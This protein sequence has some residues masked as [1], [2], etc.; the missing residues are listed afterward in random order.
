MDPGLVKSLEEKD[1]ELTALLQKML[2]EEKMPVW[3]TGEQYRCFLQWTKDNPDLE[4]Q[5]LGLQPRIGLLRTDICEKFLKFQVGTP[6]PEY[7][8]KLNDMG[9]WETIPTFVEDYKRNPELCT[10][11]MK[12][13]EI[14]RTQGFMV[15]AMEA[16]P[17]PGIHSITKVE[18]IS[19]LAKYILPFFLH[20]KVHIGVQDV[21][22]IAL[23]L[24][25]VIQQFSLDDN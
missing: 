14:P 21:F 11:N 12:Q 4:K 7:I 22:K 24:A 5:F 3:M 17:S 8:Q 2:T 19:E 20:E 6:N 18:L 25:D 1:R 13:F 16:F 15:R 23:K 10:H 9:E